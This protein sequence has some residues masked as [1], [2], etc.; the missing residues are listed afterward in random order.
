MI[1]KI[2]LYAGIVVAFIVLSYAYLPQILEGKVMNQADSSSWI[3]MVQESN[4]WNAAHP[5][6]PTEW[7]ES[8]FGGMPNITFQT[9]TRGDWTQK[10]YNLLMT[11]KRPANFLFISLLGAF[12]MMLALGIHPIVAFGGAIAVTFCSYNFQIIQVG[13]NT[14]MQAL[15]FLPWVLAALFLAYRS[16]RK[17]DGW[18]LPSILGAAFFGLAVSFQIKANHPQISY[19]LAMIILFYV[20]VTLIWIIVERRDLFKRFLIVSVLMLVLGCFGIATNATKLLP[21]LEYTPY[22]MRG[23]SSEKADGTKDNKG[24]DLDYATAWSYSWQ[25]LPNLFIPN[26]NGGSS[27]GAVNPDH[28]ATY[29]LLKQSGM[30]AS[31]AKSA[32]RALPLYW[33]PQ[34]FTAGP[35]YMGA[36]TMLLFILGLMYYK[37]KREKWWI[38][39]VSVLAVLL[40]LGCN[41]MWFTKLAFKILPLYNKFRTV[42]MVL[43][44][45]QFTLPILG[46]LMLDTIVRDGKASISGKQIIT[47][48]AVCVGLC[49]FL[50]I[51][52]SLLGSFC[53]P[54]ESIENQDFLKAIVSD[55]HSLLWAD[56]WRTILLVVC[57]TLLLVWGLSKEKNTG[58]RVV[59][60]SLVCVLLLLDLFTADKRYLSKYDLITPKELSHQFDKRPVDE[61]ILQ[62]PDLSYRVLDL[63]VNVF[64]DSH[65]SYW[66]KN[67]GGYSPA[68]LQR[69]SEFIDSNLIRE[70]QQL[71]RDIQGVGT[72][73]EACDALQYYPGLASMNCKYIILG[74]EYPPLLYRYAKGNAWFEDED[75]GMVEMTDYAPHRM[76]YLCNSES[77]GTLV[78]SEV[79]YPKG[80]KLIMDGSEELSVNLYAGTEDVPGNI[81]R[82]TRI[83]AGAHELVMSYKP[84]SCVKGEMISRISSIII[85]LLVLSAIVAS[86]VL[87]YG[88]N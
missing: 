21:I 67:I 37:D 49:L 52:Q 80:W 85:I 43:V 10:I 27:A 12:L 65:P 50:A 44:I 46:F 9:H 16:I 26:Y 36:V 30:S 29:E 64:N 55:R 33:G 28:S 4:A 74:A 73:Q 13:H 75:S 40:S 81:L 14:K 39:A 22:S 76:K 45:L 42:S 82:C 8:M 72:I 19:Y 18:V 58:I 31:K 79:Y 57:A 60:A 15:A 24:L 23:G 63:T 3:G 78:F 53:A 34:P 83:P 59:S 51:V 35:M 41:L 7:S 66:H 5:D 84:D 61:L 17:K 6:D 48:G 1:K 2:L 20:L 25:E 54:V 32:C 47:G 69:Y 87:M 86:G 88:K 77:G 56:T 62:D 38:V 68:K 70:I 71:S 11:G